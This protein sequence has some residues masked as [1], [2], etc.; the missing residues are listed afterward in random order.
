MSSTPAF[1]RSQLK[2]T[3][4]NSLAEQT[5]DIQDKVGSSERKS[6]F[7][8]IPEGLAKFRIYPAHPGGSSY[9]KP[10]VVYWVPQQ[11]QVQDPKDKSQKITEVKRRPFF[12]AKVHSPY[13][14]DVVEEYV[15]FLKVKLT[16]SIVDPVVLKS[17]IDAIHHFQTGL[18]PKTGWVCYAHKFNKDG[19]KEFGRLELPNSLN[20]ALSKLSVVEGEDEAIQVDPFT[21]PDTGKAILIT[22][23]SKSEPK[24]K[25]SATVE[26]R[27]DYRLS[28]EEL[29]VF[30]QQKSLEELF[31]QLAYKRSDF[32][33]ILKGLQIY[34]NEGKYNVFGDTEW[35]A[36]VDHISKM[37]PKDP[38]T[39]T[40]GSETQSQEPAKS[41]ALPPLQTKPQAAAPI[42]KT[43]PSIVDEFTDLDRDQLVDF[44]ADMDLPIKVKSTMGEEELRSLIRKA[45]SEEV[46]IQTEIEASAVPASELDLDSRPTADSVHVNDFSQPSDNLLPGETK[47]EVSVAPAVAGQDRLAAFRAGLA[48]KKATQA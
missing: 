33:K 34:D 15:K 13:G 3:N 31:G 16:K 35:L 17:K 25:Y 28:D 22:Y 19:T 42:Q 20:N 2:P 47:E 8:E 43:A 9:M 46:E 24:D 10:K 5:K 26:F 27:G 7:L 36:I 11:V 18:M 38:Q 6:D 41:A 21:D 23:N 44:I 12:S 45:V 1:D 37:I 30:M 14:I 39:P 48:A 40:T 32:E 4:L 29:D